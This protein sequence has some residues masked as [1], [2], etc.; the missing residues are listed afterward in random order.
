MAA[1]YP[2]TTFKICSAS[3]FKHIVSEVVISLF[4]L[5]QADLSY[6]MVSTLCG[7]F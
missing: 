4:C 5:E 2:M 6:W 1:I 3:K 7:G